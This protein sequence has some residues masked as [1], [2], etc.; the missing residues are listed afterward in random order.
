MSTPRTAASFV[1]CIAATA[2]LVVRADQPVNLGVEMGLWEVTAQAQT[3]GAIPPE[4]QQ[5]LQGMS[6]E[7]RQKVMAA[8][9]AAMADA[10]RG[11]VFRECM[12]PERLSQGFGKDDESA[13]CKSSLV[14]NTRTD[15]EYHK[16][17]SSSDGSSHTEKAVFHLAD[18]HHISGTVDVV[19]SRNGHPMTVH[20]NLDGKW[21]AASCGSVKDVEMVK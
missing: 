14:R 19:V 8:M 20:Q 11:H 16:V 12:T 15:F 5:R 9:Q 10:Q 17:C 7:Q 4:L 3:N 13:Q 18:R 2:V 21:L 6:P 1:L